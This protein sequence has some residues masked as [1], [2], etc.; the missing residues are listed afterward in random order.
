MSDLLVPVVQLGLQA[1]ERAAGGPAAV[2]AARKPG[3]HR[4]RVGAGKVHKELQQRRD[5]SRA[6]CL[7]PT[8]QD[9][10][11]GASGATAL[12]AAHSWA[13]AQK[14]NR[15]TR[16]EKRRAWLTAPLI[17]FCMQSFGGVGGTHF[18]RGQAHS[19][20]GS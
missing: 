1:R 12:L 2:D 19:F 7:G 20:A 9:R 10:P 3:G 4:A 6:R 5:V 16:P 17:A 13:E 18:F 11:G 14:K 8:R 15:A